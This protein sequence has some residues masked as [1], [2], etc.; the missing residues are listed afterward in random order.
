MFFDLGDDNNQAELIARYEMARAAG[1]PIYFDVEDYEGIF[2]YY[3][4]FRKF[5]ELEHVIQLAVSQHPSN[6]IIMTNQFRFLVETNQLEEANLLVPSLDTF[7][8]DEA[9]YL[10][11]KGDLFL[12]QDRPKEAEAAFRSA[13]YVTKE[14]K[15]S[16]LLDIAD[17]FI[18]HGLL[19]QADIYIKKA[20]K[21]SPNDQEVV[22]DVAHM[23][24][25]QHRWEES[26]FLLN[27]LI[28]ENPYNEDLWGRIAL[29][30]EGK[31]EISRAVE[32]L[33]YACVIDDSDGFSWMNKGHLH[34][35]LE[36]F[37]E[38]I[39]C[40]EKYSSTLSNKGLA[41]YFI[42][43]SYEE[44]E[45]FSEAELYYQK[46]VDLISNH[47]DSW[48][49]LG[50]CFFRNEDY[51]GS[52]VC[53]EKALE[54]DDQNPDTYNFMGDCYRVLGYD[55]ESF[56]AYEYSLKLNPDQEDIW[57]SITLPLLLMGSYSY[58]LQ[59]LEKGLIF[60]SES[61]SLKTLQAVCLYKIG[62]GIE[63]HDVL[64]SLPKDNAEWREKFLLHCE[65]VLKDNR[66]TEYF[67]I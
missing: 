16:I 28:D 45:K 61:V 11:Q 47:A 20:L 65:S 37:N 50:I 48:L 36:Q 7:C 58:C 41:Y 51:S 52:L 13:Y 63:A 12:K 1:R 10:M 66:F 39:V 9:E 30:Y 33:E 40:Y 17:L 54:L 22:S 46:A 44:M 29:V 38:A 27:K 8:S 21:L 35:R 64:A 14:D 53:L 4:A 32:A 67:N 25:E 18:E 57:H 59:F 3:F 15:A 23:Y 34:F 62:R 60:F 49:G 6:E 31:G 24:A 55:E 26:E 43:S 2:E 19:N 56:S 5:E 42:A